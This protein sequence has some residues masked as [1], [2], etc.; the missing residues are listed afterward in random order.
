MFITDF[1]RVLHAF[2][3]EGAGHIALIHYLSNEE[4]VIAPTAE[5]FTRITNYALEKTQAPMLVR[6]A[7]PRML[8][9]A[10]VMKRFPTETLNTPEQPLQFT[11][12]NKAENFLETIDCILHEHDPAEDD[13]APDLIP[14][15]TTSLF[16]TAL[17]E[18]HA[19]YVVWAR[20]DAAE[21]VSEIGLGLERLRGAL[22]EPGNVMGASA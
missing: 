13:S 1:K 21:M 4:S 18:Y 20:Q 7:N 9:A 8:L 19:A 12:L 14:A 5:F 22:V 2:P 6:R 16:L 3:S 15:I 10:F 17:V 11:L